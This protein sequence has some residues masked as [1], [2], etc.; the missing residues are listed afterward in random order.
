MTTSTPANALVVSPTPDA[1]PKPPNPP[2]A[3]PKPPSPPA[4]WSWPGPT[5]RPGGPA[6][7]A[8]MLAAALSAAALPLD[9]PG[10][11]WLLGGIASIVALAVTRSKVSWR[12]AAWAAATVALLGVG[13]FRSAD[14]LFALCVLTAAV[15]GT[16]AL[17][18][19]RTVRAILAALVVP[20]AGAVRALPWVGDSMRDRLAGRSGVPARVAVVGAVSLV[21]LL[22]FGALFASADEAFAELLDRATPTVNGGALARALLLFP[23]LFAVLAGAAFTLAGPP[24]LDQTDRPARFAFRRADWAIPVALLDLL[25]LAFVAVQATVLFGGTRHVLGPG[26]PTFADYARGGFWQLLAITGLTL[27]VVAV[28]GRWAPRADRADRIAVRV[29]LGALALLTLVVVASATYRMNVYEQAYGYTRLRVFVSA[30]ELGLGAVFVAILVAG[31]R[32]RGGWLPRAVLAIATGGLLALAVVNPDRFIADRNVDRF[33][34]T[35]R[36]D[37]IYLSSLSADAAPA[38]NRLPDHERAC[39]IWRIANGLDS[40]PDDWRSFNLARHEARQSLAERPADD[41]GV[42]RR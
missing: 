27:V 34:A 28:A 2:T 11:G 22:V 16:L 19:P 9:R 38:L 23:V 10:I 29:L 14:W 33:L 1:P 3:P 15:T 7:V 6:L 32:L 30:V 8:L 41:C 5:R 39:V 24:T 40:S 12:Q 25:F 18:D 37:L 17:I 4:G 20:V 13:T 42:Y 26:G 36:I 31:V 35:G 21:L